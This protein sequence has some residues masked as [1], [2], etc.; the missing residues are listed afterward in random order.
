MK[1]WIAYIVVF[2]ATLIF[3]GFRSAP[4]GYVLSRAN[5]PQQFA[6]WSS[7]EGTVSKGRLN[8]LRVGPQLVGDVLLNLKGINPF[9]RSVSYDI[10]WGS[11]GGR[12]A[13][14]INLKSGR[15][16]ITDFRLQQDL[17]SMPGLILAVREIGG[18]IRISDGNITIN[19]AGCES[20]TGALSSDMIVKLGNRYGRSFAPLSGTI[21]CENGLLIVA[22]DSSSDQGDIINVDGRI[23]PTGQG[24]FNI[25]VQTQDAEIGFALREYGFEQTDSG[26]WQY[27][28]QT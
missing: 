20:A 15:V 19:E 28:R 10:Q 26:T 12:G 8:T 23:S 25:S 18:D 11:P 5:I 13:G 16:K 22:L 3:F 14:F 7:A 24:A 2:V 4:L 1:K 6:S 27:Q 9:S 17:S 21:G